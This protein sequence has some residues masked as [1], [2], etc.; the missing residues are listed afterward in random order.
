VPLR[1]VRRKNRKNALTISGTL[2]LADGS[3][4]RIERRASTNN[5]R[6]AQEQGATLEAELLRSDW[7]GPREPDRGFAHAVVSYAEAEPRGEGTKRRLR[8]ILEILG[9]AMLD[10]IDQDTVTM[11]TEKLLRPDAK[12]ST[13]VRE[14]ITP[15]RAVLQHA[16]D[17][18]WCRPI[19][20]TVPRQPEGRTEYLTPIQA[21]RLVGCAA[22]HLKPLVLFVLGTGAR[23]SE[24]LELEW[25]DV[26]LAGGRCI[27]WRTKGGRR[28]NVTLP[29]RVVEA[30]SVIDVYHGGDVFLTDRG[31]P[32][33]DH[34]RLYGGQLKTAFKGAVRRAGLDP[35]ISPH[36]CRHSWASWHYALHRDPLRLK[37]DGGWASVALVERYAHLLPAGLE[38]D[39]KRF[40][41]FDL[42]ATTADPPSRS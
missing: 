11:L 37:Q 4:V 17:R 42:A 10:Y 3:S 35:S 41:G 34:G 12:P 25:R 8:R 18:Q 36:T 30:L 21:E 22:D 23:V 38:D 40:L 9:T 2:R 32:Y 13:V 29:P 26:D 31:E 6:L 33:A 1:I 16:V 20:F 24:A 5:M 14:V 28:R 39:V 15:L 7:H 19:K 27:L